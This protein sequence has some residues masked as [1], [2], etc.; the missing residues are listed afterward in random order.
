MYLYLSMVNDFCLN[1]V[2]TFLV[3]SLEKNVEDKNMFLRIK[4]ENTETKNWEKNL[5]F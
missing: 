2:M 3:K 4:W 5:N 1:F